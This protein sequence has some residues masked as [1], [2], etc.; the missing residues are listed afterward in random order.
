M[1]AAALQG[2]NIKTVEG[3]SSGDVL[4]VHQQA[5]LKHF[6]FQCGYCTPG[7]LMGVTLLMDQLKRNPV[8]YSDLNQAVMDSVGEHLCRCSGYAKYH[9][10]IKEILINTEGLVI[11]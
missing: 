5:L 2:M 11:R 3:L 6:S 4:S 1:P 7:F 10:A 8:K 9:A